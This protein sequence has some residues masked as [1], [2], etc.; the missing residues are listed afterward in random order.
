MA[1]ANP[2]ICLRLQGQPVVDFT[3]PAMLANNWGALILYTEGDLLWSEWRWSFGALHC[4]GSFQGLVPN[5]VSGTL[6]AK[7]D[8]PDCISHRPHKTWTCLWTHSRDC[9][10]IILHFDWQIF[11]S[12][13]MVKWKITR[14]QQASSVTQ[15]QNTSLLISRPFISVD[16]WSELFF[17]MNTER[18]NVIL[19]LK[20]RGTH[21]TKKNRPKQLH[22][23]Q[24]LGHC[25]WGVLLLGPQGT[26]VVKPWI[27]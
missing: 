15:Q 5:L 14:F 10:F 7:D 17:S 6:H 1:S 24:P 20:G 12:P 3:I 18:G 21:Q 11:S 4:T 8:C 13:E 27:R 9:Q 16:V 26:C 23:S 2:W 19:F 25:W 22:P